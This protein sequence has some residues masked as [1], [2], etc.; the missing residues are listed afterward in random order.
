MV[1]GEWT[2]VDGVTFH[3]SGV[4]AHLAVRH[5]EDYGKKLGH[6]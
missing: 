5:R 1:E 3:M 4:S 2:D 6:N